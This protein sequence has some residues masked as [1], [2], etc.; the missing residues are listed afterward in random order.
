[1]DQMRGNIGEM[2]AQPGVRRRRQARYR[3]HTD[4]DGRTRS[5]RRA[6]EL[7]RQFEAALGDNLTDGQ[8]LAVARA[9]T[10]TA[11]AEDRRTRALAGEPVLLDDLVRVENLASRAVKALGLPPSAA[12]KPAETPDLRT[13]LA[14]LPKE[15]VATVSAPGAPGS[16]FERARVGDRVP[17]D[18]GREIEV[19][20]D[21]N[22]LDPPP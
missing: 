9:A 10:L 11:I 15:P 14:A 3:K 12:G 1:M 16:P 21:D 13:Y 8:R 4:I 19:V 22:E 2:R 5:G 20:P 7:A 6:R 17:L 18:D